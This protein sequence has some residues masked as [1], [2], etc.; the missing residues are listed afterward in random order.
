MGSKGHS[1]NAKVSAECL[2]IVT[3]FLGMSAFNLCTIAYNVVHSR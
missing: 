2:Q 1:W 3:V